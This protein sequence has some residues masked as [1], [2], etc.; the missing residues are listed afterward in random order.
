M[1]NRWS[2]LAYTHV[3]NFT[4]Y[5]ARAVEHVHRLVP[6]GGRLLDVPAGNGLVSDRLRDLDFDVVSADINGER[7]EYVAFDMAERFPFDDASLDGVLCLEGIEHMVN[8][9]ALLGELMRILRPGGI[10][11]VTTP[12]L[13]CMYSRLHFLVHGTPYQFKPSQQRPVPPGVLEDRGHIAPMGYLQLRYLIEHFGGRVVAVDG[14]KIK[15]KMLMPI[16]LPLLALSWLASFGEAYRQEKR[17]PNA[18]LPEIRR[19]VLSR[20]LLFGRSLVLVAEAG[21]SAGAR[22]SG[23]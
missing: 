21:V 2:E 12:N 17:W 10:L 8:P 20:P 9:V 14:D 6:K 3:D 15:R 22:E 23:R 4:G 13:M 18:G 5:M 19:H 11:V 7:P 16:Y 1:A